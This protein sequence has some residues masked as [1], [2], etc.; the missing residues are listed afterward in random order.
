LIEVSVPGWKRLRLAALVL[1]VNGALAVDG[2][3]LPEVEERLEVLRGQLGVHL[4]SADTYG[5]LDRIAARLGV[6]ASRLERGHDESSQKADFVR[7]LG[8]QSVAAIGKGMNDVG[9]L[10]E[11]ALGLAVV[12][13]EGLATP[14]MLASDLVAGSIAD[15]LDLLIH[16]KR[17]IA[18]LRR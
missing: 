3:L 17:L 8:S 2:E 7:R 4:L 15:A 14:G 10:E 18:S 16:P 12:G 11:A 5:E 13:P 6:A 1:D 9:M